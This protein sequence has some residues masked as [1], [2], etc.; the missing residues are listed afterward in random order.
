MATRCG[1]LRSPG[2]RPR[3]VDLARALDDR[4]R[5]R[6]AVGRVSRPTR[7]RLPGGQAVV[8]AGSIRDRRNVRGHARWA[9][10]RSVRVAGC[11][12]PAVRHFPAGRR[13]RDRPI[14]GDRRRGPR[15]ARAR[16][17]PAATA[18]RARFGT[19][20]AGSA[21]RRGGCFYA[22][23]SRV[24]GLGDRNGRQRDV[25]RDDRQSDCGVHS[26]RGARRDHVVAPSPP[27]GVRARR[28]AAH[29][30]SGDDGRAA[31]PGAG[32]PHARGGV[33]NR[34]AATSML[35]AGRSSFPRA[36]I[37]PSPQ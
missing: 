18:R 10:R 9:T 23:G 3:V 14:P 5:A 33:S 21:S 2:R 28:R 26:S 13:P 34:E 37:V 32:R 6:G 19:P 36:A 16:P 20:L 24:A 7:P 35:R 17:R 29:P 25:D 22:G 11:A 27:P 30:D 1:G 31:R 12:R 15:T 8:A 4:L